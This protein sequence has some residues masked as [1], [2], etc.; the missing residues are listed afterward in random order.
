MPG[1][2]RRR[3][4]AQHDVLDVR[5]LTLIAKGETDG[6]IARGLGV[7]LAKVK[8]SLQEWL[9]RLDAQNRTEAVV[10]AIAAGILNLH[11]EDDEVR[12]VDPRPPEQR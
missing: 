11:G 7:P 2:N 5:I 10:R 8:R 12:I 9:I 4:R 1:R 3:P 6:S